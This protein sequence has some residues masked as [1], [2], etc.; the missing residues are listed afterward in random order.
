MGQ[1]STGARTTSAIERMQD[2]LA[3]ASK[4]VYA[5]WALLVHDRTYRANF[6]IQS[7]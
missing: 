5:I 3:L 2:I 1:R 7:A 4:V 6:V